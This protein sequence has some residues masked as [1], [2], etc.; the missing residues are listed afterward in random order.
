MD[1][2]NIRGLAFPP[3][4]QLGEGVVMESEEE[5][6][7]KEV[8]IVTPNRDIV[9]ASLSFEVSRSTCSFV[10]LATVHT[11]SVVL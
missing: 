8:P 4:G 2:R 7:L 5:I 3:V 6:V 10:Y 11:V 9:V 1:W